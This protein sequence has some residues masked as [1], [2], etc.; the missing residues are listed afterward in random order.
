MDYIYNVIMQTRDRKF[1]DRKL[2]DLHAEGLF[3]LPD[4]DYSAK[5]TW[6]RRIVNSEKGRRFLLITLPHLKRER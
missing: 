4:K 2:D 6:F 1:L 3:P 5:Y